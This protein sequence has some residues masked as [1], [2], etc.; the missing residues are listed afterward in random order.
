M[1]IDD[2]DDDDD[3]KEID[4]ID[5]RAT[6]LLFSLSLFLFAL[7]F[8]A[9]PSHLTP[10]FRWRMYSW[11]PFYDGKPAYVKTGSRIYRLDH[12]TLMVPST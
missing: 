1:T 2:D 11:N 7:Y 3:D 6:V 10:A 12:R 8:L 5:V 4:D 9:L